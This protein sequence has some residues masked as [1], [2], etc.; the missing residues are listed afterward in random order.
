MKILELAEKIGA[1]ILTH[2]EKATIVEVTQI[3]A[4][5]N[6][7]EILNRTSSSTLLVTNLSNTLLPRVANLI[8]VAAVC[9]VNGI[10]PKTE[11]VTEA[12]D[13]GVI[14]L[15]SPMSLFETCGH[16]HKFFDGKAPQ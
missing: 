6:I 4:G 14:L 2:T 3:Y 7:S 16:L 12:E 1:K 10:S 8:D 13:Q 15:V 9:L 11:L 5:D